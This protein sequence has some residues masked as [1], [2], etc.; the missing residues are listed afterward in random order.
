MVDEIN[1]GNLPRIFGELLFLLEYRNER[2]SLLYG[3]DEPFALPDNLWVIGTM[4]TADRSIGLI[5]GALRRRFH[6]QPLFPA[7]SP[8]DEVLTK[9]LAKN[10]PSMAHV[11]E[12]VDRLNVRL[13]DRFGEQIQI[14]HSYF[15]QPDL[16]EDLLEQIWRAD[17]LPFLEEQLFGHE[18]ELSDFSLEVMRDTV[19]VRPPDELPAEE[20]LREDDQPDGVRD[21]PGGPDATAA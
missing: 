20:D 11:A 10:V 1:R 9:W 18:D 7:R 14:G 2:V 16:D 21:R 4:N 19:E 3:G 12:D 13:R 15:M 5:D 6:F 17:I 8:I